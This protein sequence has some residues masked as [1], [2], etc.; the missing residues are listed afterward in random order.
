MTR[1]TA[2]P[3]A[4]SSARAV[5]I[6]EDSNDDYY[7]FERA[8]RRYARALE[9][10]RF[11]DGRDAMT[12]LAAVERGAEPPPRLL[13]LDLNIPGMDGGRVLRRVKSSEALRWIPVV[14]YSTSDDPADIDEAYRDHANAFHVKALS[15][16]AL[17]REI[18][19]LLD[20]WTE[21]VTL[22]DT[23]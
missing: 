21:T 10:R 13:V 9:L 2:Q 17:E 14:I 20:Y 5:A 18:H 23:P 7:A 11:R 22:P 1:S 19:S 16:P 15:Y 8:C 4:P 3:R 6:V 12:W